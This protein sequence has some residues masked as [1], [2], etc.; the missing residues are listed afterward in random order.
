MQRVVHFSIAF[1][2]NQSL[3][4]ALF[5]EIPVIALDNSS[6]SEGIPVDLV[7]IVKH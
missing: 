3:R 7:I 2:N 4:H 1:D 6:H 5:F